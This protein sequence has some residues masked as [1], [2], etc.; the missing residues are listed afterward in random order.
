MKT[1]LIIGY[2]SAGKNHENTLNNIGFKTYVFSRRNIENKNHNIIL[3]D[4]L[5]KLK[6]NYVIVSNETSE[7]LR[8]LRILEQHRVPK[9]LVE[10]PIFQKPIMKHNFESKNI[11]VGYNLRFHPLLVKL[12]KE[13][14]N[15][16]FYQ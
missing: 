3:N 1:A 16:K 14:K 15:K 4:T 9:V 2:G 5:N 7:H 10:K 12:F 8:T 13:I 11:F 6:P